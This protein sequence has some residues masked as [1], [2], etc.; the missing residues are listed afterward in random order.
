[1]LISARWFLNGRK[2]LDWNPRPLVPSMRSR[3]IKKSLPGLPRTNQRPTHQLRSR[4]HRF[5]CSSAVQAIFVILFAS[6]GFSLAIY[7]M[8]YRFWHSRRATATISVLSRFTSKP[9]LVDRTILE[10]IAGLDIEHEMDPESGTDFSIPINASS[11][12]AFSPSSRPPRVT[13]IPEVPPQAPLDLGMETKNR[14]CLEENADRVPPSCKFLLPLRVTEQDLDA[15]AH[16]AQLLELARALNR[17]LVLPNVGKNRMGACHRWRFGVYY[18]EQAL[19]N[20]FVG[21]SR[22]VVQQDRFRTW[23]N[24]LASPPSS[25]LVSLNWTYH[26]NF[27]PDAIGGQGDGG[28]DFYIHDSS[29]MA[30][31]SYR[32]TGCLNRKFPQLDPISPF[33]PLSFVVADHNKQRRDSGDISRTLLE[34]LSGQTLIHTQSERLVK[35]G[36][37]ATNYDFNNTHV[38]PDVLIVS[39]NIPVPIFQPRPTTIFRYSPQLRALAARLVR[40]LSP[41]IAV[42]W[43]V[44]TSKGN[45]VL[46]CVEAL[47][48]ALRS[49]LSSNEVLGIR[50]IWL[51]GNLSP[52]DLLYSPGP[53]CPSTSMKEPFFASGIKLTGVHQ[54]LERM[55]EEG[56]EV[57]DVANNGDEV[58]RK[59]EALKDAGVLG[60][61]D[62]LVSMR[63]TVFVVPSESCGK[64][65]CVFSPSALECK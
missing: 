35:V 41:Y 55:A 21:S 6:L 5:G 46:G 38:S 16:L 7:S 59:Q 12:R 57:D 24:S 18:D 3:L 52:S 47:R 62:K 2:Y 42:A 17:T 28:V 29:E 33:P 31:M 60:I 23:V 50:N 11:S 51:A 49:V 37:R 61:L 20:E 64:T 8:S 27:L 39:W 58:V 14:V 36:D 10:K 9:P 19:S 44:E 15:Q 45:T 63:S 54:E 26:K 22:G 32:Q 30:T 56:E 13:R 48:S 4:L 25:Q 34:K 1:M 43:N 65:R 53:L 40:R